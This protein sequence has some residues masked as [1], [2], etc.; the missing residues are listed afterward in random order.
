MLLEIGEK[1]VVSDCC[2]VGTV[3][4]DAVRPV[5]F[6]CSS[7]EV[8]AQ[9]LRKA[10]LLRSKEGYETVYICPDRTVDER[11][12]YKKLWEEVK[13]K[14]KSESSKVHIIRNNKIVSFDRNSAS[15]PP[16]YR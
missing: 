12:A 16:D 14:R 11:R 10:R 15:A 7:S 8:V 9:V 3:K 13:E 2:R 5:K 1:P 6:S 4:K